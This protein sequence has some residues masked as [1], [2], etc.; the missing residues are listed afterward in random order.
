[1]YGSSISIHWVE[2]YP[3]NMY[4]FK[5]PTTLV[6]RNVNHIYLK[7]EEKTKNDKKTKKTKNR[8]Y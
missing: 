6:V 5:N 1:M 7:I 3:L 8:Q 4:L 2:A